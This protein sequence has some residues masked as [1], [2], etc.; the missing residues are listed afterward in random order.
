MNDATAIAPL[1]IE[2][3]RVRPVAREVDSMSER[4]ENF[5]VANATDYE[6]GAEFLK[7]IKSLSNDVEAQR[8]KITQPLD[9]AKKQVMD[10]FRPLSTALSSAESTIKRRLVAWQSEQDRIAREERRKAEERS[11][12]ERE[13]LEKQAQDAEEKGRTERADILRDRAASTVVVSAAPETPKVSGLSTRSVWKF[14]VVDASKVPD[15]Y[16]VVDEKKVGGVVRALKGDANIP[17]VR[18]WEE[19]TLAARTT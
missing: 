12:R 4:A 10:L 15:E 11:R 18:I 16:K 13:R 7:T 9:Q 19:Q 5:A 6:A 2:D 1:S 17:G 3:P 14:E 8:K